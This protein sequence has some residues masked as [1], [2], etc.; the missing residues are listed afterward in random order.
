MIPNGLSDRAFWTQRQTNL[1]QTLETCVREYGDIFA[2]HSDSAPPKIIISNPQGVREIFTAD[3]KL[4]DTGKNNA[5][6]EP[7][8]GK[9]SVA[10]LD[11]DRHRRQ[12][13]LLMPTFH[14]ER[15]R[16]Y[17]QLIGDITHQ[18]IARWKHTESILVRSCM[19]ELTL[20][21]ILRAVFGLKEGIRFQKLKTLLVKGLNSASSA[22]QNL[23]QLRQQIDELIYAEIRQ[24]RLQNDPHSTDILSLL[25]SARD[26][27]DE[28]MTN[29]EL[30]DELMTLLMAGHETTSAALSWAFYWI[31]HTPGVLPKILEELD[32]ID[33]NNAIAVSRLPYLNAVCQETLRYYPTTVFTFSRILKYPFQVMGYQFEPGTILSPCPYLTHH[34]E[35]IYANPKCFKPERFQHSQFS[36]YEYYPFGGSNRRCIGM[37]FAQYEMK[38]VLA[39]ILSNYQLQ[40]SDR[41]AV[42]P[43]LYGVAISPPQDMQM[44]AK[45]RQRTST[46]CY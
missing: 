13:K 33:L 9:H 10:L 44:L 1:L 8:V 36:P 12:R 23:R 27:S 25:L 2:V 26:E 38:L 21:V 46:V 42:N 16:A 17:G 14:G 40:L 43:V 29:A 3:P 37:A 20:R 19:Q 15:M 39:N 34:R 45:P 18:I 30:R 41:G 35:D 28:G 6:L 31:H 7:F 11:G 24:R 5:K 22:W 4:F 32:G